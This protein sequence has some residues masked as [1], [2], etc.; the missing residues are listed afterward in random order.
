MRKFVVVGALAAVVGATAPAAVAHVA[1]PYGTRGHIAK[2][3]GTRGHLAHPY[4]T[5]GAVLRLRSH[6]R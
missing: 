6:Q 5:R 1:K 2:P 4:G 3:Y